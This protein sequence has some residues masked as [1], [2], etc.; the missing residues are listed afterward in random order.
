MPGASKRKA[1]SWSIATALVAL[2][3]YL[4]VFLEWLFFATK[5][6]FELFPEPVVS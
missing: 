3:A 1:I 5:P 2:T 4:Y 6:S